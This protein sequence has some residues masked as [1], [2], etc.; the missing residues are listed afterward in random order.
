[1]KSFLAA[2]INV[3]YFFGYCKDNSQIF[4]KIYNFIFFQLK[5]FDM[6]T[7]LKRRNTKSVTK[8]DQEEC[9]M[10]KNDFNQNEKQKFENSSDRRQNDNC[11]NSTN[12]TGSGQ[13]QNQNE[14]QNQKN[15]F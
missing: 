9:K 7:F 1:M 11:S 3:T 5:G 10:S 2:D 14:K 13:R 8:N 4:S 12:S 6:H 15:N